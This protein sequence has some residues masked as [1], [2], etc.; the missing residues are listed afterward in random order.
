MLLLFMFNFFFS[1]GLRLSRLQ[2]E[3]LEEVFRRVHFREVDL[4][5]TYLD[6]PVSSSHLVFR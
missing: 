4:E 2:I 1:L 3:T 5:D 6:E